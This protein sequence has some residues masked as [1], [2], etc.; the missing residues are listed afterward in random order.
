MSVQLPV[1]SVLPPY[2]QKPPPLWFVTNGT[3]TV[4]PVRTSLLLRGVA[5]GRVPAECRIRELTWKKWRALHDVREVR[6]LKRKSS[7]DLTTAAR[8][9]NLL[10]RAT[11]RSERLLLGLQ[12]A[13][14]LTSASA[15]LIHC[16]GSSGP[17][18][19][20]VQGERMLGLLGQRLSP[21]DPA[22]NAACRARM[23][24]GSPDE[25]EA[26]RS[27]WLR[28]TAGDSTFRGVA[29]VPLIHR[30]RLFG[31]IELGRR[32]HAFRAE[33]ALELARLAT[34][35]AEQYAAY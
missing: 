18:I 6:A 19:R 25:G 16:L 22:L 26:E 11:D 23:L 17:V 28:L 29:M 4:G 20:Y 2:R 14:A 9:A 34:V 13:V 24:L 31:A 27:L 32:E 35:V 10:L 7:W 3:T 8:A 15:G 5:H 33:D 21:R 30:T 1:L 12:A